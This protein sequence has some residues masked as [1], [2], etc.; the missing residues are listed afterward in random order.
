MSDNQNIKELLSGAM[1]FE[2][3]AALREMDKVCVSAINL[4]ASR[5]VPQGLIV[6]LLH[7]YAHMQTEIMLRAEE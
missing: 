6:G 1:P 4:A 2:T 7:G 5:G 3:I